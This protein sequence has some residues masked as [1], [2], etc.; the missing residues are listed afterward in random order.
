MQLGCESGHS[1]QKLPLNLPRA[2]GEQ[3]D[4]RQLPFASTTV[5]RR[6]DAVTPSLPIPVTDL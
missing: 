6:I 1:A 2:K 5:A 4:V 3:T